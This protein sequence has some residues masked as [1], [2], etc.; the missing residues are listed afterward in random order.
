MIRPSDI[1]FEDVPPAN[2]S[3][4]AESLPNIS[5][6]SQVIEMQ[7]RIFIQRRHILVRLKIC[8][9]ELIYMTE[10]G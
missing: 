7:V 5:I 10:F 9:S 1:S 3:A 2:Y 6:Q 4:I 8:L